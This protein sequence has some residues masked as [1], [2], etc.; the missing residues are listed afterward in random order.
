MT[1][2]LRPEQAAV[3]ASISRRT[4]YTWFEQGL[5][6]SRIGAV[7]LVKIENMDAFLEGFEK[8]TDTDKIVDDVV[9][10]LGL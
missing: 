1:G 10:E 8:R 2:W 3:Y 9:K 6:Y 7:R 4:L 5:K